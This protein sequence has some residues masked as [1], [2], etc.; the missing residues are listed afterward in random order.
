MPPVYKGS[1]FELQP[2]EYDFQRGQGWRGTRI[3][4][5]ALAD[6]SAEVQAMELYCNR[7]KLKVGTDYSEAIGTFDGLTDGGDDQTGRGEEVWGVEYN[8]HEIHLLEGFVADALEGARAGA[9]AFIRKWVQDFDKAAADSGDV[10]D[11]PDEFATFFSNNDQRTIADGLYHKL[12][13]GETHIR[14]SQPVVVFAS[15]YGRQ[16]TTKRAIPGRPTVYA[17]TEALSNALP[18]PD[19]ILFELPDGMWLEH[20]PQVRRTTG[21]RTEISQR[22]EWFEFIDTIYAYPQ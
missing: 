19:S 21:D 17:S 11:T 20:P 7:I 14:F 16:F 1:T 5:G 4:K 18:I 15:T 3:A 6:I 2:G 9:K 8:E 12:I 22:W 10:I 13:N